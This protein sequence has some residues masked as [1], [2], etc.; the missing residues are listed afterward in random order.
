VAT[1]TS[2]RVRNFSL[3]FSGQVVSN[4][5]TWFQTLALSLVVLEVTG[6]A[7]ALAWVTVAQFGPMLLLGP[8]AGRLAD[9]VAPRTILLVTAAGA[10]LVA[11]GLAVAVATS[12]Q[13]GV[14]YALVLAAGCLHAFERVASQVLIFE[15]VGA[16]L[17]QNAVAL[18]SVALSSAR[19]IGPALAGVTFAAFGAVACMVVNAAS[20]VV[21]FL[22]LLAIDRRRLQ[23]RRSELREDRS[24]RA[25][26]RMLRGKRMLSGLL[27]VNVVI[28][29]TA[30]NFNVVLTS[31]AVQTFGGTPAQLGLMHTLNAVGAIVGG[32]VVSSLRSVPVEALIPACLVFAISLVVTA[33]SPDLVFFVVVAPLLGAGLG[34]YQ[35]VLFSAAQGAAQPRELGRVMGLIT[36]GSVGLS[37]IGSVAAG[38]ISDA[39]SG[40]VPLL[41]G[42]GACLLCAAFIAILARR[43]R[44]SGR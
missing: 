33:S 15:L 12:A 4:A 32:L 8:L 36:L 14:I 34:F 21:I 6:S 9:A 7:G 31:L 23:R 40:Q 18:N 35:G 17:L 41:I 13:L 37:P 1:F 10:M 20:Y 2:L 19:S 43:G 44:V 29:V 42:A 26:F 25:T 3:F 30:F 28:A 38:A 22:L 27:I 5:G 16:S 24:F 39:T 11:T